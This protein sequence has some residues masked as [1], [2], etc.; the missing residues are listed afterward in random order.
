[1]VVGLSGESMEIALSL[2]GLVPRPEKG[3]APV[4]LPAMAEEIAVDLAKSHR[5]A[6]QMWTLAQVS[7]IKG[8]R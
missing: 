4:L 1:M 8:E 7:N 3:P 5:P 2:V 6:R